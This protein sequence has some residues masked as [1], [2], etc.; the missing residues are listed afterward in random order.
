MPCSF[1]NVFS[2]DVDDAVRVDVEADLDLRDTT[3]GRGQ[4]YELELTEGTVV[5]S[6]LALALK[7]VHPDVRLIVRGGGEELA[8]LNRDS[9]IPFDELR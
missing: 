6:K 4:A 1:L 8:L 7:R 5:T 9:C 3:W 2:R